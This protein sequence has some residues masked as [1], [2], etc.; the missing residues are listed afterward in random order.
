MKDEVQRIHIFAHSQGT[1][2]TYE[3]L[4]H[5]L[6]SNC[7][8]KIYTYITIG[9]VLSYYHQARGILDP[10]Y[11][12]RFPVYPTKELNLNFADDYKWMNFWNFTDPITEF[13]GL[14]EYTSFANVPPDKPEKDYKRTITS[15]TNRRTKMSLTKNHGEYW[16]N[17]EQIAIPF[18]KRVLRIVPK[19]RP[20]EWKPEELKK[21]KWGS[22][23]SWVLILWGVITAALFT[24]G[25][26]FFI[27][28][29]DDFV[30][31][32]FEMFIS[33]LVGIGD[34]VSNYFPPDGPTIGE[35]LTKLVSILISQEVKDFLKWLLG[36]TYFILAFSAVWE[37]IVQIRRARLIKKETTI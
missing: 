28:G 12:S 34:I 22:H 24:G 1:P 17:L 11:H 10:V 19:G 6:D 31:G 16:T 3:S 30:V 23:K 9:S 20:E 25:T 27:A 18:A 26:V 8:N 37:W 2:I 21:L 32:V 13:Y 29:G 15:P 7:Q 4:Y 33:L 36:I 14:D 5:Y 35:N